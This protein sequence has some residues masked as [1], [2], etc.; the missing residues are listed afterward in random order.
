MVKDNIFDLKI[1]LVFKF[2]KRF[3]LKN[4]LKEENDKL[5]FEHYFWQEIFEAWI[6]I[7]LSENK[8]SYLSNLK[9]SR[10]ILSFSFEIIDD[11][12]IADL[13]KKWLNKTGP[14]DVLSF[15]II[16]ENDSYIDMPLIELGDL[17]IS[18]DTAQ[19]QS[20]EYNNSLKAEMIW[21]ASHGFLHLLGWDHRD[22][23]ELD[24]M[25]FFQEYLISKLK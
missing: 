20:K 16:A 17:F 18:L 21:L 5:I 13:N 14:T 4:L 6:N 7:I 10:H 22:S 24:R 9:M 25:L 8:F 23:N 19:K 11:E 2:D 1:D 12:S 15:P 3:R